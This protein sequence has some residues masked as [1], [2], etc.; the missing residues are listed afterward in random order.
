MIDN[1]GDCY[2][3]KLQNADVVEYVQ[4]EPPYSFIKKHTSARYSEFYECDSEFG[5]SSTLE[6]YHTWIFRY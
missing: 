1:E 3:E 5:V 6:C 2:E 4:K